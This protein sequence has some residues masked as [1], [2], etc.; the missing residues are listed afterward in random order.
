L[1]TVGIE[2]VHPAPDQPRKTF[3]DARLEELAASIRAQ[4]VIQPLVVRLRSG[5]GYQLIAGERRWRAAQ[6]AGLHEVPV[7]VR[8]VAAAT[9]F[10]LAMVENLQREDLNPIEEAEGLDRLIREFGYTQ[11][12]L[13]TRVGKDRTT[14]T[15]SLRLLKL[16]PG[17]RGLVIG[18][19]L[20]MGHAR[21]ILGLEAL[22]PS[23]TEAMERLG[24][25]T[26]ARELSVRQVEQQ[27]RRERE[28]AAGGDAG[29]S[30]DAD[31]PARPSASARDLELR[32]SRSF[33]TRVR[34]VESGPG[35]GRLEIHYG[36][37]DQ[38]DGLLTR[39]L[40]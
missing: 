17:V 36:S 3:D 9:A 26:A 13:A 28:R 34:V 7:V 18:G 30:P 1:R 21:A 12:S 2:E 14:V 25:Q 5:G 31:A 15:N 33:G 11:E 16:P 40:P 4:G 8:D 37:L 35:T 23:G 6:R 38:L 10:E 19:R 20:S 22:G 29:A 32:L 27:V 39:L 24:R